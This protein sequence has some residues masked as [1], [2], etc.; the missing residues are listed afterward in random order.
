MARDLSLEPLFPTTDIQGD[1]LVGLLKNHEHLIFF[2]IADVAKFKAFLHSLHIT[3]MQDCL[4][5]R[6]MI[7]QHKDNGID[8]ILPT[9][10]LNI[11]F[12]AAGLKVLAGSAIRYMEGAEAEQQSARGFRRHRRLAR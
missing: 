10:G 7:K 1:I 5:Q 8:V 2:N 9:P 3:S 4:D 12:T 6:A 11:A